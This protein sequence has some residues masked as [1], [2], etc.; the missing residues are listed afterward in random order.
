MV[1][2]T[3]DALKEWDAEPGDNN[4]L[5]VKMVKTTERELQRTCELNVDRRLHQ[6][7]TITFNA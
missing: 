4:K 6:L 3:Q 1:T 5:H 2:S 7:L